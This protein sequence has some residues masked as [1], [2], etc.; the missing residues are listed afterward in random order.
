MCV[1][2]YRRYLFTYHAF[3]YDLNGSGFEASNDMVVMNDME[4][5]RM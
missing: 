3:N 4:L 5:Q 2:V 1:D